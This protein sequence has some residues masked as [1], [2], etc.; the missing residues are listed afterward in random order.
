MSQ[1]PIPISALD[2]LVSADKYLKARECLKY[3]Y[4]LGLPV[5]KGAIEE[6]LERRKK[7]DNIFITEPFRSCDAMGSTLYGFMKA[8]IAQRRWPGG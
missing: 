3:L 6:V 2:A 4:D 7:S 1:E 5:D 8:L